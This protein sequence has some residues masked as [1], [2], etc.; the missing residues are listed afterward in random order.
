MHQCHYRPWRWYPLVIA[1]PKA[2]MMI[3]Y[4]RTPT[5]GWMRPR[6]VFTH[7][8]PRQGQAFERFQEGRKG[9]EGGGLLDVCWRVIG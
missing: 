3:L 1:I 6:Y 5:D 7:V 4:Q 9:G 2:L 8:I